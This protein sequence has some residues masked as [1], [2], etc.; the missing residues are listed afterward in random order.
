MSVHDSCEISG[1]QPT[2]QPGL[3]RYSGVDPNNVLV[4]F[5]VYFDVWHTACFLGCKLHQH[6]GNVFGLD[7]LLVCAFGQARCKTARA[8]DQVEAALASIPGEA[9]FASW[10][11]PHIWRCQSREAC[12]LP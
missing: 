9:N 3:L 10:T 8:K 4:I 12:Q 1:N 6:R 7:Q 2:E 11:E 5:K